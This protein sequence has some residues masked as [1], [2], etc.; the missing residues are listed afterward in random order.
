MRTSSARQLELEYAD[1][2]PARV[3]R[4][5]SAFRALSVAPSTEAPAASSAQLATPDVDAYRKLY[6]V[7]SRIAGRLNASSVSSREHDELLHERQSL[8][9]K[10]LSGT[11]SP[12]EANRLEY[13]RWSLDRIEDAQY[14]QALDV[15][16]N[17]VGRYEHL[18]SDLDGLRQQLTQLISRSK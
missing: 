13:V 9:D 5:N 8:L 16:E 17:S 18:L 7:T 1:P 2:E 11:I 10:K 15:L 6:A 4:R 3:G 12:K 14:G